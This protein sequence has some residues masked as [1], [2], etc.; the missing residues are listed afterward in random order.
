MMILNL[1][2]TKDEDNEVTITVAGSGPKALKLHVKVRDLDDIGGKYEYDEYDAFIN[3]CDIVCK[4]DNMIIGSANKLQVYPECSLTIRSNDLL[5]EDVK[6]EIRNHGSH[7]PL[8][9]AYCESL[10]K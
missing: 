7:G 10:L 5:P 2:L 9:K 4:N 6:K 1:G 8:Y 3:H